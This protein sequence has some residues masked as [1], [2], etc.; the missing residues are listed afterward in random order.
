MKKVLFVCYGLGIGGIEKCLVNLIN[1]LPEEKF[2]IDILLMNPEFDLK[3]QIVRKVNFVDR[4]RYVMNTTDTMS[5]IRKH[6]GIIRKLGKFF[7]Y[8]CF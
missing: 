3:D 7:R 4:Y 5:E 6:V 2:D 1:V 8:F